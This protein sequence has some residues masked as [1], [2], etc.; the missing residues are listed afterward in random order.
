MPAA[1]P[2]G[3]CCSCTMLSHADLPTAYC[4]TA[5]DVYASSCCSSGMPCRKSQREACQVLKPH[6]NHIFE[7]FSTAWLEV[8]KGILYRQLHAAVKLVCIQAILQPHHNRLPLHEHDVIHARLTQI[9]YKQ[10]QSPRAAAAEPVN[11]SRC[12]CPATP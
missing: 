11:S 10:R 6:D 3:C 4:T 8:T 1:T 5:A 9:V 2:D 7:I 12:C